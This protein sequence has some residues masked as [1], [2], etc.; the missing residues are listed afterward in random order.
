MSSV[1][2]SASSPDALGPEG[3]ALY[4]ISSPVPDFS[5]RQSWV[6][7]YRIQTPRR[8]ERVPRR[9]PKQQ[10]S[11][12]MR[13]N[14][15]LLPTSPHMRPRSMSPTKM[16]SEGNL[17]PWRIRVT[18]EAEHED[19]ENTQDGPR[20]KLKP[21]TIT[22]KVPLKD[23]ESNPPSAKKR[24]GRPRKSDVREKSLSPIKG[25]PGRTP[26]QQPPD[27][28]KR[29][30]GQPRKS[31]QSEPVAQSIEAVENPVRNN[32]K[33]ATLDGV[34]DRESPAPFMT[35]D[36]G[37]PSDASSGPDPFLDMAGSGAFEKQ[38]PRP[39]P[40]RFSPPVVFDLP[41]SQNAKPAQA[42]MSKQ[43]ATP[44][45]SVSPIRGPRGT[46][47]QNT[48]HAG[49]TPRKLRRSYPTPTSS[50]LVDGNGEPSTT[51]QQSNGTHSIADPT[52]VHHEYDTIMESEDFSMVSLDTLPSAKQAG[53]SSTLSSS[54]S[55]LK[56]FAEKQNRAFTENTNRGTKNPPQTN[57]SHVPGP[58]TTPHSKPVEMQT[59][60][61]SDDQ[62]VPIAVDTAVIN[63][64]VSE[65]STRPA[66]EKPR[67]RFLG[68]ARTVRLGL[69]LHDTLIHQRS[70]DA[71]NS[72][73]EEEDL[74]SAS[75]RLKHIFSDLD[76]VSQRHLQACLGSVK[77]W[78]A[79]R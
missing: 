59:G 58:S 12:T 70:F 15:I 27:S 16:Q 33:S 56:P 57:S 61:E 39:S 52:D 49:H 11:Q 45:T 4:L 67:K 31:M 63:A 37:P 51:A 13:F 6:P 78:L 64:S 69:I 9:T 54:K 26:K 14:D 40:H 42:S 46:T 29:P 74:A 66:V 73:E 65:P 50:S 3:D 22:T 18:V 17:S 30:R 68:L 34:I 21:S 44:Q 76:F 10:S 41:N 47:P 72:D 28:A 77:S 48:L 60:H 38:S 24:R 53:L 79:V 35:A 7:P 8:Q 62:V 19:D 36:M 32:L 71:E 20:K 5:G 43:Q 2:S 23:E 75:D 55:S 25:S 1:S